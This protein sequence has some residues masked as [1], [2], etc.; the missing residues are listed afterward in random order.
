MY[1]RAYLMGLPVLWMLGVCVPTLGA[2]QGHREGHHGT[3][4]APAPLVI[5]PPSDALHVPY[6]GFAYG[7][8]YHPVRRGGWHAG[9]VFRGPRLFVPAWRAP[10]YR[11]HAPRSYYRMPPG[12]RKKYYGVHPGKGHR[13]HKRGHRHGR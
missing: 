11:H 3:P 9:P 4:A 12:Q 7:G 8:M 5:T 10:R 6:N 13:Y 1:R 2:S